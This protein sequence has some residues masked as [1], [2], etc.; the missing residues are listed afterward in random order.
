[1]S[2]ISIDPEPTSPSQTS[3]TSILESADRAVHLYRS[4]F[5]A[6]NS[7]TPELDAALEWIGA[8]K[9]HVDVRIVT[10]PTMADPVLFFRADDSVFAGPVGADDAARWIKLNGLLEPSNFDEFFRD[11]RDALQHRTSIAPYLATPIEPDGTARINDWSRLNETVIREFVGVGHDRWPWSCFPPRQE[12]LCALVAEAAASGARISMAGKRHSQGGHTFDHDGIVIDMTTY[13][14]VMEFD[15][16]AKT[17]RVRS[18]TTWDE[19]QQFVQPH[20]LSVRVMQAYAIFTVGG[21]MGV[22][23][24]DS[25]FRFG[26][27]IETVKSFHL[28]LANG[29]IRNVSRDENEDLFGLVIGGYGLIGLVLDVELWLT[30]DIAMK[31]QIFE[32]TMSALAADFETARK[33][34]S[35]VSGYARPSI[36]ADDSFFDTA[37][38]VMYTPAEAPADDPTFFDLVEEADLGV[39]KMIYDMSR[40]YAWAKTFRWHL[41]EKF[42]DTVSDGMS[43]RNNLMRADIRVPG[44][45]RSESDTD[46]VQEYFVPCAHL[47]AFAARLREILRLHEVNVMSCGVRFVPQNTESMLSYSANGD[48]FGVVIVVNHDTSPEGL[49]QVR[50][51]TRT[52]IDLVI[53]LG[54]VYYLPYA[55]Y[56]TYDQARSAYPTIDRFFELKDEYDPGHVF[57]S[58]FF[59]NYRPR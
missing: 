31:Q 11:R 57:S 43:S 14:G 10:D 6:S 17:I 42:G 33:D 1:M 45:Y 25:D 9:P 13:R 52:I 27:L 2:P 3:L 36:A 23:V 26:P 5:P 49:E 34:G 40:D 37:S 32:S 59:D 51:W 7:L 15:A 16:T 39:R 18:G 38:V 56:A 44:D 8:N 54:G 35:T 41:T 30:D 24:H 53:E 48:V 46:A 4:S 21:S 58:R 50:T 20:G 22:N 29:E 12:D 28:L 19:I 55:P 47:G